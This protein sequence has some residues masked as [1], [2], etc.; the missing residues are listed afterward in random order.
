MAAARLSGR[1]SEVVVE[2]EWRR[3]I[4]VKTEVEREGFVEF[5][6]ERIDADL[7]G[8]VGG[9]LACE[10]GVFEGVE[11]GLAG[12]FGDDDGGGHVEGCAD[13]TDAEDLTGDGVGLA[14][15]GGEGI[16]AVEDPVA[17]A[18][19]GLDVEEAGRGDAEETVDADG[20]GTVG[21]DSVERFGGARETE[22]RAWGGLT[23]AGE[24]SADGGVGA[25]EDVGVAGFAEEDGGV[26][27]SDVGFSG[28]FAVEVG[29][30]GAEACAEFEL[31]DF[32]ALEVEFAV[33]AEATG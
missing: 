20:A 8:E 6:G 9:G 24:G 14:H 31:G 16:A 5:D 12:E 13:V 29:V 25:G 33:D 1:A 15:D 19:T 3:L 21:V 4:F 22:V 27:V 23:G 11:D 18:G 28:G 32:E 10:S 7:D 26:E 2:L 17:C 30:V